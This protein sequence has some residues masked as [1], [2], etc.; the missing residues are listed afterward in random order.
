MSEDAQRTK[1][2]DAARNRERLLTAARRAFAEHG[3]DVAFEEIARAADVSRTT[4]YRN[5]ATRQELVAT[6]YEDNVARIE[7]HAAG[8][9]ERPDGVVR[10]LDFVLDQQRDNRSLAHALSGADVEWLTGLSVR[11]VA[12]FRPHLERG[13]AAGFV[14][15]DV[16]VRDLM[17]AFPMAAGAMA[18]NDLVHRERTDDRVRTMLHRAL[19][20]DRGRAERT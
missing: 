19:F 5:F 14:H 7:Q 4:I 20:T 17:L 16:D 15:P 8:L 11:T 13:R 12:A 1:R 10:L 3:P 18:D 2:R 9:G 6:V